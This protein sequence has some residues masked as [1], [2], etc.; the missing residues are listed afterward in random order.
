[1]FPAQRRQVLQQRLIDG[2]AVA[3]QGM[4]CALQVDRVPQ[5]DSRR[6]QVEAAGTVALLLKAAVTDFAQPVEE[7]RPG[8]RVAGFA[9]VQPGMDAA[10]QLDALQ[11]VQ[12]EQRALDAPQL[13]QGYGQAI[14]A[15]MPLSVCMARPVNV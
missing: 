1:M 15:R 11:P 2:M 6:H 9:L 12:D 8:Q 3:T 5:H 14:L 13:A 7:H 4:R 10:A